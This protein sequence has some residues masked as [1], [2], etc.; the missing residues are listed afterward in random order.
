M[1]W[2]TPEEQL[3]VLD[4]IEKRR[5]QDK[6]IC[7]WQP[8]K[9]GNQAK[10]FGAFSPGVKTVVVRGGN[11]S[12]KSESGA[13]IAVAWALGKDYFKD[14]PGWEWVKDLPIPDPPN[15]IWVV[16]LDFPTVKNVLWYEKFRVGKDH[17]GFLPNDPN[18]VK[19]VNE[20]DFQ[21]Y[22]RNGSVITCKSADSGREKFQGASVDLIWIDEEPDA[23]IY[24]ECLQRTLDCA[25]KILV[26][27]T[28]L[29][30]VTS[31]VAEPW[32]FDLHEAAMH[33]DKTV[34]SI[35]L[36]ILDNPFVPDEEKERAKR[37]WAG[38]QE[39][40]ARLYGDFIRRSGL[41]YPE[42]NRKKHEVRPIS[43]PRHWKRVACI[44]PAPTGPTACVWAAVHPNGDLYLYREYYEKDLVVSE[45]ARNIL[46]HNAGD[47][48]DIWLIDPKG[49]SQ[50]NAE[51]HKTTAQLYIDSGI[52]V[53]L[54]KVP[55][56]YGLN[57][58]REYINATTSPTVPHPKVFVF[59]TL[60][61]FRWEIEHYVWDYY[62][63]GPLKGAS[64]E[65]PRKRH[66]HLLNA[67]QYICGHNFRGKNK[68]EPTEAEK[69][70]DRLNNSYT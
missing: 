28:P 44:D 37:H 54:A 38:K 5:Q 25:G 36:S 70:Q 27:V 4:E 9:T 68:Y 40:G 49:G 45:H 22:F 59:N 16:G 55:E 2:L 65:K 21:I 13:P 23:E 58:A 66:D 42:W 18:A 47:S 17:P 29:N 60:D 31:G 46:A 14:E 15:N 11:R 53:R 43:L 32:V 50:R 52:P 8:Y 64:K 33:G 6:F 1:A 51:T 48:I 26:T 62:H 69:A 56:D 30:D 3:A 7:Y 12:G 24:H 35:A 63:S 10:I 39:E 67:F 41:V 34:T 57:A 61:T 19:K 20:S